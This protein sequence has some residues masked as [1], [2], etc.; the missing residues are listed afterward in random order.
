MREQLSGRAQPCQGWGREFE[1]RFPLQYL[2]KKPLHSRLFYFTLYGCVAKWLCSGLQSHL[3]RFDSARSLQMKILRDSKKHINPQIIQSSGFFY[4]S[5]IQ[6][7]AV[8][9]D[10][11]CSKF[12]SNSYFRAVTTLITKVAINDFEHI[13]YYIPATQI[14]H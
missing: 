9:V 12:Y 11:L 3:R 1:S 8:T 6:L 4:V 14:N 10:N 2:I 7:N 13:K 5:K